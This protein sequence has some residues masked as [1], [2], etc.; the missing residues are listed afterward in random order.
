[1]NVYTVTLVNPSRTERTTM[2]VSAPDLERASVAGLLKAYALGYRFW[3]V[4][5]VAR[6]Y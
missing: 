4:K 1:M 2:S 6:M 5:T 3:E